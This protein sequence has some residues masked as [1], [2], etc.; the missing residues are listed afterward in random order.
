MP[1]VKI[2][3]DFTFQEG[4]HITIPLIKGQVKDVSPE[5]YEYGKKLSCVDDVKSGKAKQG[6]PE[7]KAKQGVP[8]NKA[9]ED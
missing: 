9:K 3:K 1:L 4:G 2:T 6:A 7:N 5:C 8:D